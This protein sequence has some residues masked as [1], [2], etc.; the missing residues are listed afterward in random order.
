MLLVMGPPPPRVRA[1]VVNYNSAQDCLACVDSLKTSS[2]GIY[3]LLVVD[4]ASG[5]RDK[6][7]L[8]EGLSKRPGIKYLPLESNQGFG[9]ALNRGVSQLVPAN[10]DVL[11]LCNADLVFSEGSIGPLVSAVT[12][13][14]YGLVSPRISSGPL[15]ARKYWH[16]GGQLYPVWGWTKLNYKGRDFPLVESG[17]LACSFLPGAVLALT[18]KTFRS[19]GNFREDL[20]LYFEDTDFCQR[21]SDIGFK[22]GCVLSSDVWHRVGGSQGHGKAKSPSFFYYMN[23]N[24]FI[25]FGQDKGLVERL[26]V[27]FSPYTAFLLVWSFFQSFEVRGTGA[28][29]VRGLFDGVKHM[30]SQRNRNVTEPPLGRNKSAVPK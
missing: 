6:E 9:S 26:F 30:L 2:N 18:A 28:A 12:D 15:G 1:I 4:S 10:S 25:V 24:R 13:G 22:I 29:G 21:A 16:R 27:L 14:S 17:I 23:R 3:D 19:V 8:E 5:E 7:E 11:L 20:F